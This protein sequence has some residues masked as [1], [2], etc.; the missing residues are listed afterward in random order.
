MRNQEPANVDP[1]GAKSLRGTTILPHVSSYSTYTTEPHAK[2]TTVVTMESVT[3]DLVSSVPWSD[4]QL[5]TTPYGASLD[6]LPSSL[7]T[8]HS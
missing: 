8:H 6:T 2:A 4:R 3:R 7:V 5:V 1:S